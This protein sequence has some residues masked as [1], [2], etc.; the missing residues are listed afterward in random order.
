M[1]PCVFGVVL[2]LTLLLPKTG[3]A[4][5]YAYGTPPP[6]VTAATAPWQAADAPII[7]DGLVFFP[8]RGFRFFDANVMTQSGIYEGVPVY[9]DVTIEP[10]SIV[11]V[12]ISRTTMRAYERRRNGALAGTTGSRTP[13]FP[14]EIASDTVLATTRRAE[15]AAALAAV[16]AAAPPVGTSGIIAGA[17]SSTTA[18]RPMPPDRPEPSRTRVEIAP[19][20][21]PSG[22]NGVWLMYDG[23]RWYADGSAVPFSPD[24]FE[25]IG[26]YR[27]FPVYRA[28]HGE[29]K[30]AIWVSV[31]KD[32]PVAPYSRR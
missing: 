11:Y 18:T 27:G 9:A 6:Q 20:V 16:D 10:Y 12:P 14:V 24:R 30:N 5:A 23:A 3:S 4:Q 17:P 1:R 28:K 31:V 2:T 19:S 32:G 26:E 21:R 29:K 13:S 15:A 7:V 22:P 25:P 8:T